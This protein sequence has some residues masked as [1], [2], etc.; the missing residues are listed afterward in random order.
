MYQTKNYVKI[1]LALVLCLAVTKCS[2]SPQ[3][4]FAKTAYEQ[5]KEIGT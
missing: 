3:P 1:M 2:M 4:A 5:T